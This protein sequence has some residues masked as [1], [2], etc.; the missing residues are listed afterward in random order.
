MQITEATITNILALGT[1]IVGVEYAGRKR[2]LLIG[3]HKAD[4]FNQPWGKRINR[5]LRT[6]RGQKYL[7]A[8]DQNDDHQVKTFR[9]SELK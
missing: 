2:N 8:V 9:L 3:A 6:H 1:R 7:V 4:G 5:A